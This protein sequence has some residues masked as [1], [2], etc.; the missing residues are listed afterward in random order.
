[1]NIKR[2]RDILVPLGVPVNHY[3]ALEKPDA[4]IVWAEDNQGAAQW[5]DGRMKNQ[6]IQGAIHYFTKTEYDPMVEE[7]QNALNG[8]HV[9]FRLNS[10]QYEDDTKY[11]HYEWIFEVE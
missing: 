6:V 1:M 4:Y 8:D 11:I 3:E 5:A 2:I 10:I 7:I 9:S